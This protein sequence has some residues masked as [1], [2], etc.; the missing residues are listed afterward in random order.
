[1]EAFKARLDVA[2]GSMVWWLAT[3]HI[4]GG[5]NSMIIVVLFNPSHSMILWASPLQA[6]FNKL[7]IGRSL[8][9]STKKCVA[10]LCWEV[11]QKVAIY[12]W[13][14]FMG[15]VNLTFHCSCSVPNSSQSVFLDLLLVFIEPDRRVKLTTFIA[16]SM[17]GVVLEEIKYAMLILNMHY[18]ELYQRLFYV[19]WHCI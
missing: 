19:Y 6:C 8:F 10:I 4:A 17:H 11:L 9:T 15:S 3:L 1:M 14:L 7:K 12:V 16:W 5:W 2:L 13:N 18:W